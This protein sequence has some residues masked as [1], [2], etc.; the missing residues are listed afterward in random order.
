MYK[1]FKYILLVLFGMLAFSCRN[2]NRMFQTDKPLV[3]DSIQK[4]IVKAEEN[5]IIRKNDYIS[6]TVYTNGGEKLIDPNAELSKQK[7][8]TSTSK[9]QPE[10]YLVRDNGYVR[11]PMVGDVKLD[12]YTVIKADSILGIAYSKFYEAPFVVTRLLNKRVIVLGP[13]PSAGK[14]IP[15]E[16]ENMNIIEIIALYGGIQDNGKAY[17]IRL[18]RGNLKNPNVQIIDLSTITGMQKASLDVQPN[19]IIYIEPVRKLFV[20]S[21]RDIYPIFSVLVS[22]TSLLLYIRLANGGKGI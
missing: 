10:K 20:E 11:L 5:Y 14:V 8:S 13:S 21:F 3:V 12:G 18:I 17:N 4:E 2:H 9:D 15:L 16:N 6:V 22:L 19:D 7:N 1:L